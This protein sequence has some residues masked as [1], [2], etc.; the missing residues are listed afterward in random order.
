MIAPLSLSNLV[1]VIIAFTC[2]STMLPQARG[3]VV[4]IWR[5]ALPPC[6][7]MVVAFGLLSGIFE[8]DLISDAEWL[9][10][11]IVG[12]LLG[13]MR[14]WSL[15]VEV[16]QM[17]NLMRQRRSAD[18]TIA[19]VALVVVAL[20]DFV[21]AAWREAVIEPEHV[22]AAA[23]LCAGF[24]AGRAIALAVRTAHLPHITLHIA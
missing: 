15:P 23:A 8:P 4:K 6:L 24:L 14:G 19:A 1:T 21:S 22:A 16:D 12:G 17:S 10:A 3:S 20:V 5:L 18:A 9:V 2:L 11:A 13:R 7:A